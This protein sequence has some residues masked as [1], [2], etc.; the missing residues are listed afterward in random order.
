MTHPAAKRYAQAFFEHSLE[1]QKIEETHEDL[2]AINDIIRHAPL[3][4]DAMK[5]PRIPSATRQKILTEIFKTRI[6]VFTLNFLLLLE[7]K[8]V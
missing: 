3:L 4:N 2:L 5:S 6:H 8:T 1:Q 7:K